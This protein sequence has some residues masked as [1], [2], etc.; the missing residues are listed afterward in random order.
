MSKR[1]ISDWNERYR[2][3]SFWWA[4]VFGA[5]LLKP[6]PGTWGSLVAVIAG[7]YLINTGISFTLLSSLIVAITVLSAFAIDHIEKVSGIHDAPEIVIDEVAGQWIALLPFYFF[8]PMLYD[9]MVAFLLFRLFDI[10]KP[11]PIGLI[12]RK[13]TG[14]C[15]VMVDDLVAGLFAAVVILAGHVLLF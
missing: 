3:I 14:G 15:G 6:A 4:T 5:G 8:T 2:H 13:V 12:D 1:P 7:Y 10:W 11:W 9:Y